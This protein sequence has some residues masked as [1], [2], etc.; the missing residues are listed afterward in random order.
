[1]FGIKSIKFTVRGVLPSL[2]EYSAAERS[3][4]QKAAKMKRD[5]QDLISWEIAGQLKGVHFDE[6]VTLHYLWV[7]PNK[8][9]DK[10]NIAFAKK[11]VQ[12]ALVECGVLKNDT[13]DLIKG[14]TDNFEI[15]A[16][17]PRVEIEIEKQS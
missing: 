3:H 14:F 16:K 9:K 11:F 2:N 6:P 8:R 17:N 7:M 15:D 5:A 1:M 12:D 10:D 4:R 13:W